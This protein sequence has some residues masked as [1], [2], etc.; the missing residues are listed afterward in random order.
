M[1]WYSSVPSTFNLHS[2]KV[3][4]DDNAVPFTVRTPYW[5]VFGKVVLPFVA[6]T[7]PSTGFDIQSNRIVRSTIGCKV[8]LFNSPKRVSVST[9]LALVLV[10]EATDD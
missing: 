1:S 6:V 7:G 9:R 3:L 4:T 5:A 2:C 8:C 10:L